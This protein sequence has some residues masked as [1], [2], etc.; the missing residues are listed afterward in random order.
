LVSGAQD[1]E[2]TVVI[3][4]PKRDGWTFK[5]D[6]QDEATVTDY[7][8]RVKVKAGEK[9][10]VESRFEFVNDETISLIDADAYTLMNWQ[11]AAADAD[12]K[13]KLAELGKA[14]RDQNDAQIKLQTLDQDYARV[15]E[16][17]G[18]VRQNLTAVGE[19]D[20]KIRFNKQL[21]TLE[22]KLAEIETGRAEQRKLLEEFNRKVG[23]VIR[24]F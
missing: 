15:A 1:G 5:A 17:Q 24:S 4:V 21:T 10:T 18:R 12:T 22:D 9:K 6:D 20:S 2:R 16:E 7:R 19:G 23:A 13:A 11:N 3:E 8:I 14:R